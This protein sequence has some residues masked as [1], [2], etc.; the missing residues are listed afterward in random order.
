MVQAHEEVVQSQDS[1]HGRQQS[2]REY[3]FK[4]L[5]GYGILRVDVLKRRMRRSVRKF[6]GQTR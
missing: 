6:D 3:M 5:A 1:R 2:A 4:R